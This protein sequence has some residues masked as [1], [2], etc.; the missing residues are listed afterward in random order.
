MTRAKIYK[1]SKRD[2]ECRI[3]ESGEKIIARARAKLLS[4]NETL[5]VGDYVEVERP[6]N[7]DDY[8]IISR[9]DR[10]SEIYRFLIRE[11]KKKVTAANIDILIILM[12]ISKP[13]YKQGLLD[14]F[15]IRASQWN[16]KP[17]VVFNKMDEYNPKKVDLDF[18]KLRLESMEIP[19]FC[20]SATSPEVKYEDSEHD[21]EALKKE[22]EGKAAIFLGQSGVGKSKTISEISGGEFELRTHIVGKAG[23]GSHTTTWSEIV[24]FSN[25]ELIDSPG[26]RS[27]SL[28]D[29]DPE[30]LIEYFPDL[31]QISI[32]CKFKNCAHDQHSKGCKFFDEKFYMNEVHQDVVLSRLDSYHRIFDEV[33]EIPHWKK[34]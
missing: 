8:E 1:S 16:L 12:S 17:I 7:I 27:F 11:N 13:A 18:E 29:I 34:V 10:S 15:L 31:N 9:E 33:S 32:L 28:D 3:V 24:S 2:F 23:K 19:Y 14:R 22:M 20:I 25:F 6:E 21:L 26:I 30:L 5:V 4:K